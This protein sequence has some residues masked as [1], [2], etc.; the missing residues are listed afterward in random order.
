RRYIF[1]YIHKSLKWKEGYLMKKYTRGIISILLIC[2]LCMSAGCTKEKITTKKKENV[3]L[4]ISAAASL[5]NALGDIQKK[6]EQE[7]P[8]VKLLFNYGGSGTL[9]QQIVQGA[10]VDIFFSASEDKFNTLI[11]KGLIN[12]QDKVDLLH[13]ELV[14]IIPKDRKNTITDFTSL[15]TNTVSKVALGIPTSVPAGQ[16]GK[17]AL[18]HMNIWNTLE[19]KIVYAKDVRQVLTYVETKNVDAGIVYQTDANISKKVQIV[20]T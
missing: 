12:K 4:T 1:Y 8:Y 10:P 5:Q 18:T 16:Y 2:I 6:Y 9:Q 3:T 7:Y 20:E 14:L 11:D 13:N 15:T 17:Q 19:K